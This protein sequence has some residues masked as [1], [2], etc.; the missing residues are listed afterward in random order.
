MTLISSSFSSSLIERVFL[1]IILSLPCVAC[2]FG[3]IPESSVVILG[4]SEGETSMNVT[5]MLNN[6]FL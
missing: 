3:V 4:E 6:I 5:N 1:G 2:A